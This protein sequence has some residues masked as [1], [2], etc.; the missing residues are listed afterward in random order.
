L[1]KVSLYPS[2]LWLEDLGLAIWEDP[3]HPDR[4]DE[5]AGRIQDD[6]KMEGLFYGGSSIETSLLKCHIDTKNP[7]HEK[8]SLSPV[9]TLVR[10][11]KNLQ[12][13]GHHWYKKEGYL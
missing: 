13:V 1:T 3:L 8:P 4:N 2:L 7:S 9:V 6:N 11:E 12:E 10:R 5:Y